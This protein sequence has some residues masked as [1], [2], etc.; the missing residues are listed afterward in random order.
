MALI[1]ALVSFT[2]WAWRKM[3]KAI[4]KVDSSLITHMENDDKIHH[5]LFTQQRDTEA[6]LNELV[7]EHKGCV[8]NNKK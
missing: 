6:K 4:E 2:V 1:G 7:G 8:R 5:T 3:E